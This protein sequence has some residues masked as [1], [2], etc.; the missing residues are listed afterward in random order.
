MEKQQLLDM[1]GKMVEIRKFDEVCVDLKRQDLILNG[2]HSY[3]GQ[4]AVAVGV[5]SYLGADEYVLSSHRP[6]GHALAKGSDPAKVLAEMMGRLGGVGRGRG[7]PM[8]FSDWENHF[9]ATS[10]VGSGVP[11][12]TGIGLALQNKKKPGVVVSIFGDGAANTGACHEGINLGSVWR[13]PV[14]FVC[15]NNLY[16]EALPFSKS[17]A[18]EHISDRAKGYGIEGVTVDGNDVLAVFEVA[19]R[20]IEKARNGGGPSLIEA[21]TYRFRGHYEGDPQNYRTYEEV[22]AWRKK[23][24]IARFRKYLLEVIPYIEDELL[25]IDQQVED[26]VQKAKKWALEQPIPTLDQM[27]DNER[28]TA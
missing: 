4:E 21:I 9:I 13:L 2:F 12:A 25:A 16:G 5:L 10:I 17:T 27:I 8:A 18:A 1:Y 20:F 19:G 7:G 14:V 3:Q 6:Q 24:P 11:I 15:E 26:A 28:I 22:D 23:C